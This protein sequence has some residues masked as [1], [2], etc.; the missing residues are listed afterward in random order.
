MYEGNLVFTNEMQEGQFL[1]IPFG[2][3]FRFENSHPHLLVPEITPASELNFGTAY[4]GY[5]APPA[6]PITVSGALIPLGHNRDIVLSGPDMDSFTF[7]APSAFDRISQKIMVQ[8]KE[9]LPVGTHRAT[10]TLLALDDW[11]LDMPRSVDVSFTVLDPATAR[12]VTFRNDGIDTPVTA[13][14]NHPID[15]GQSAEAQE[16]YNTSHEFATWTWGEVGGDSGQAFWG[17]FR[18]EELI[19]DRGFPENRPT[20]GAT[21]LDLSTMTFTENELDEGVTLVAVWSH[22]GDVNDDGMVNLADILLLHRYLFDRTLETPH[23]NPQLNLHAADV[24]VDGVVDSRDT[25]MFS[26]W[27]F[28]QTLSPHFYVVLGRPAP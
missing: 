13:F 12:T 7:E 19:H 20:L 26:Q 15:W 14:P 24:N 23:F 8:P 6:L 18:P 27:L 2:A 28:D 21:G 10:I 5:T 11:G 1:T 4:I 3:Y 9:G 17:W 22:W 16:I 25:L